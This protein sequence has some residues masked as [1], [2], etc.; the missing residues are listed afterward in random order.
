MNKEVIDFIGK[1]KYKELVKKHN[2]CTKKW[3]YGRTKA[4]Y[5]EVAKIIDETRKEKL[6]A[7]KLLE[8]EECLGW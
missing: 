8:N 7:L 2:L 1:D 6:E 4:F 3:T 5:K